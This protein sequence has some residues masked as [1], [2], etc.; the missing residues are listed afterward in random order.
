MAAQASRG[1]RAPGSSSKDSGSSTKTEMRGP[2]AVR[3]DLPPAGALA[4][5][6]DTEGTTMAANERT[7]TET[8]GGSRRA[9]PT[10]VSIPH[11]PTIGRTREATVAL[12]PATGAQVVI[13]DRVLDRIEG[14]VTVLQEP[15]ADEE[16][17]AQLAEKVAEVEASRATSTGSTA[18]DSKTS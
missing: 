6:V 4:D 18:T 8:R 15:L 13:S 7:T 12:D 3:G 5:A 9:T 17:Q 16:V 1:A 2:T 11:G 14:S 10:A